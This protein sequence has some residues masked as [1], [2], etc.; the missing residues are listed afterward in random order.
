MDYALC[1]DVDSISVVQ[2]VGREKGPTGNTI[3]AVFKIQESD[4]KFHQH[5]TFFTAVDVYPDQF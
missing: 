5:N 4:L 3:K 1:S 2:S